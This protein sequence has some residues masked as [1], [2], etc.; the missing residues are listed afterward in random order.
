MDEFLSIAL[1][2]VVALG[3]G[4]ISF[5][6]A[7]ARMEVC[8]LKEREALVEART[9]IA[10]QHKA[11]EE[12]LKATEA[13]ARRKSLDDFL[14]DVRVE[15][16]HYLK[17]SHSS[18]ARQRSLVLQERIY[19]RNI[20]LSRWVEYEMPVEDETEAESQLQKASIFERGS[21][22]PKNGN[23]SKLLA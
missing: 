22:P 10:L 21:L 17:E 14:A 19:F 18:H 5:I 15:E 7:K 1:P 13:E 23:G 9:T 12:R 2:F 4:V 6:I 11:V 20:P 16:R 8:L 3:S